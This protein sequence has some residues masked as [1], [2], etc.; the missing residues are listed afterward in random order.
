[1][2]ILLIFYFSVQ[3]S[4][5]AYGACSS[6][7]GEA[8]Q[9]QWLTAT[10]EMAFC[11]DTN[12]N[13]LNMT[14]TA[15]ACTT[16]GDL[17]YTSSSMHYCNGSVLVNTDKGSIGTTCTAGDLGTFTYDSS[18]SRM[19]WCDGSLWRFMGPV[20]DASVTF[21][22]DAGS[23]TDATSYNFS[24]LSLG[25]AAANRYI[26][27]G[28]AARAASTPTITGVTVAGVSATSLYQFKSS[29]S[30]SGFFIV[31][32]PTGTSGDITVNFDVTIVRMGISVW[33]VT[34][35]LSTTPTATYS[36][37]NGTATASINTGTGS[38]ALA[39]MYNHGSTPGTWSGLT[40]NASVIVTDTL[41]LNYASASSAFSSAQ[42]GLA[43]TYTN[44]LSLNAGAVIVFR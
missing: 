40:Q 21:V 19:K 30:M 15:T 42:S 3:L 20:T 11:N 26:V 18:I 10:S 44:A 2:K 5:I 41:D 32:L 13:T 16:T 27:V 24:G 8:G 23:A 25:A 6:P 43:V 29:N 22:S 12:W 17:R 1:M 31:P 28:V 37:P 35:I 7:A 14:T 34:N 9:M 38:V 4:G 39:M 36:M 33:A